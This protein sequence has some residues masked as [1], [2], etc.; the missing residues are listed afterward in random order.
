MISHLG[1][2]SGL[3]GSFQ[4]TLL[5]TLLRENTEMLFLAPY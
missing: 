4:T 2:A 5:L 1:S 3:P